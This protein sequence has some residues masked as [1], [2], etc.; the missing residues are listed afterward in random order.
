M[1]AAETFGHTICTCSTQSAS[2][3]SSAIL[4]ACV[5]LR[6]NQRLFEA[7]K[8]QDA[9]KRALFPHFLCHA[10]WSLEVGGAPLP[11]WGLASAWR[12]ALFLFSSSRIC[13]CVGE[14]SCLVEHTLPKSR[15]P[16]RV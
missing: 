6:A 4:T 11:F 5:Q 7:T 13:E 2:T 16:P 15:T 12:I 9:Q 3:A 1:A 8:T 10:I 14:P